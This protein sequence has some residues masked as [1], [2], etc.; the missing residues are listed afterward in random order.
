MVQS[1]GDEC[2]L[3]DTEDQRADVARARDKAA[4]GEDALLCKRPDKVH[5]NPDEEEDDGRDDGNEARTAE[6][7]E[8]IRQDNLM[9][10]IV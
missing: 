9:V 4:E 3:D 1:E 7:G 5:G 8:C 6:E 10:S 2:T